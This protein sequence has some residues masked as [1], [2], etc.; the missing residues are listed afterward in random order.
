MQETSIDAILSP[1]G[2]A[3]DSRNFTMP[4]VPHGVIDSAWLHGKLHV[5]EDDS[6][7]FCWPGDKSCHGDGIVSLYKVDE[8]VSKA[9]TNR[10][11]AAMHGLGSYFYDIP[12]DGWFARP[13]RSQ[14]T[15]QFW[16]AMGDVQT[17]I[18]A[19]GSRSQ[20][21]QKRRG[22][23]TTDITQHE[24][25][26]LV[27]DV[28]PAFFQ[29]SGGPGESCEDRPQP[30]TSTDNLEAVRDGLFAG[31]NL[32]RQIHTQPP[33][34]LQ[35]IGAPFRQFLLSDVLAPSFPAQQLKLVIFANAL[36]M[37]PDVLSAVRQKLA[38]LRADGSKRTPG[39]LSTRGVS[40]IQYKTKQNKTGVYIFPRVVGFTC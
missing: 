4:L 9:R 31:C 2:Y 18:E 1:Y 6:R 16:S 10:L 5:I 22:G 7:L 11:V 40:E 23:I 15:Q 17:R 36:Q 3:A 37:R 8:M 28:S 25:A 13:D 12:G 14:E 30:T 21:Q 27:D 20:Q 29:L 38:V 39:I 34:V 19:L 24:V 32:N 33:H 26:L 35:W